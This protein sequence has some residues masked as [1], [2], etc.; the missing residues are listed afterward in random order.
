[1][2]RLAHKKRQVVSSLQFARWLGRGDERCRWG[3]KVP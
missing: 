3:S 1:M 2:L